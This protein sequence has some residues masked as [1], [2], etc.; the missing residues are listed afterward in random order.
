MPMDPMQKRLASSQPGSASG[1]DQM[2]P[3]WKSPEQALVALVNSQLDT[4]GPD[5]VILEHYKLL[6]ASHRIQG[7][8][9]PRNVHAHVHTFCPPNQHVCVYPLERERTCQAWLRVHCVRLPTAR[10][11]CVRLP[12]VLLLG[13]IGAAPQ[14]LRV[15]ALPLKLHHPAHHALVPHVTAATVAPLK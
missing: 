3:T 5:D 11:D 14:G 1:L 12:P 6:G 8:A 13:L 15:S 9:Q 7:S 10:T 2:T 4:F